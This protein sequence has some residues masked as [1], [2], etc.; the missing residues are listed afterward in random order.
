M[1][2]PHIA[3]SVLELLLDILEHLSAKE[4]VVAALVCK[5]WLG[6]AVDTKRTRKNIPF[7]RL[8]EKLDPIRMRK[9]GRTSCVP[10]SPITQDHWRHFLEQ[11]ANRI[12]RLDFDMAPDNIEL[13]LKRFGGQFGTNLVS[14][15][16]SYIVLDTDYFWAV[17]D[18]F[19]G[20]KL[21]EVI[22]PAR[23]EVSDGSFE[24]SAFPQLQYLSYGGNLTASH[25]HN[26]TQCPRL[27]ILHLGTSRSPII[28]VLQKG[29]TA[30]IFPHL[31]EFQLNGPDNAIEHM[32]L[33]SAMPALRSLHYRISYAIGSLTVP[34]LNSI[35]QTSPH[36]ETITIAAPVP[37]SQLELVRHDGL[38]SLSFNNLGGPI[39]LPTIYRA[40]PNLVNL[41]ALPGHS[42]ECIMDWGVLPILADHLHHLQDLT[43]SL[44][45]STSSLSEPPKGATQLR[46]LTTPRFRSLH[47]QSL[48]T[49]TFFSYLVILC[50]NIHSM[51]VDFLHET[52]EDWALGNGS[53]FVKRFFDYK[54]R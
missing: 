34:L 24:F 51:K 37:L 49:E 5:A 23:L 1:P 13:L 11:F 3:L 50:P 4:L 20:T 54:G 25:Y 35:L 32:V 14:L 19:P 38:Q 9:Y 27:K 2:G 36:L 16:W 29:R 42:A 6:P 21:R 26:L 10:T 43:L 8:L 28:S 17:H 45:V 33:L 39:D 15:S 12:T 40:F 22:F 7:S 47:I 31:E 53:S 48:D 46:T 41:V 18:L 44:H 30:T 52:P